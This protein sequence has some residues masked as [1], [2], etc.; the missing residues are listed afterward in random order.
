MPKL[1]FVST[2]TF[3]PDVSGGAELSTIKLFD[4]LYQLGWQIEIICAL[5]VRSSYFRRG[6]WR[7]L[8]RLQKPSLCMVDYDLG[9]PCWRQVTALSTKFN[10]ERYWIELIDQRLRKY[11]PDVVLGHDTLI[12]PLLNYAADQGYSSFYFARN[13]GDLERGDP[14]PDKIQV[15][16]NSPFIAS[17]ASQLTS[18]KIEIVLPFV[19]ICEYKVTERE[20]RYITFIN[21]IPEKGVEVAIKIACSLPQENFLFVKGKWGDDQ[22]LYLKLADSLP[23]VEIWDNQE[24][25]R[26]VYAVTDILLV[27]SHFMETFGRVII[28]AQAN[29]IPVIASSVGGIPYTLGQGGILVASKSDPQ[30]YINALKRLCTDEDYYMQL[31]ALALQNSQRPEFDLQYQVQNFIR[32]V[33]SR[34]RS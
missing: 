4:T 2:A 20:R 24:D 8:V 7:S 29:G 19:D 10:R 21:P 14:I 9:Y 27:P 33:E 1:L 28:E 30:P 13:L 22:G 5:S 26:R 12:C 15:I 18:N 32:L 3:Y 23:N 17:I 31:S 11:R 16:A 34:I 25:M 6:V